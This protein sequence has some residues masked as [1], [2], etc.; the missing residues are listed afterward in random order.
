M[1]KKIM[2][3]FGTVKAR[4]VDNKNTTIGGGVAGI[5]LMAAIGQLETATGCHFKEAF[6]GIDWMQVLGGV[7]TAVFGALMTDGNKTV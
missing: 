6:A 5:A 4:T 1:I 7:S 3:F 2:E